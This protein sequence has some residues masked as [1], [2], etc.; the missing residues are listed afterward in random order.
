MWLLVIYGICRRGFCK[1]ILLVLQF[2]IYVP[3][4]LYQAMLLLIFVYLVDHI[5]LDLKSQPFVYAI[6]G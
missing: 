4:V 6:A 2:K 3:R 1:K 5:Q